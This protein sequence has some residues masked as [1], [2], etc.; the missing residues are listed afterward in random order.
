MKQISKE[1]YGVI[2]RGK[3]IL[4]TNGKQFFTYQEEK[5]KEITKQEYILGKYGIENVYWDQAFHECVPLKNGDFITGYYQENKIRLHNPKGEVQRVYKHIN[6][7]GGSGIY[8]MD[9]DKKKNLWIVAPAEHYLGV[10]DLNTEE[11]LFS[12]CGVDLDPTHL[13]LPEDVYI[14]NDLA[15]ISDMGNHRIVTIHIDT[16]EISE[17]KKVNEALYSY[18]QIADKSIYQF[19]S[20]IY[21]E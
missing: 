5:V 17:Y 8:G 16:F 2:L 11:E 3:A 13:Y 14:M 7:P 18:M 10:F 15:Y 21:I 4:F 12:I 9:I 1:G 20:G 6:S 19:E